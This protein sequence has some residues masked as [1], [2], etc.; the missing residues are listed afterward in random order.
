MRTRPVLNAATA[1]FLLVMGGCAQVETGTAGP[2]A[3][4]SD[5]GPGPGPRRFVFAEDQASVVV[6]SEVVMRGQHRPDSDLVFARRFGHPILGIYAGNAPDTDKLKKNLD[7][8]VEERIGGFKASTLRANEET[9]LSRQTILFLGDQ[10]WP[11]FVHFFYAG[12]SPEDAAAADRIIE[13][14]IFRPREA[15]DRDDFDHR[16]ETL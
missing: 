2:Q 3:L 6:T 4:A 16:T 7:A 12:L 14:M 9:G 15:P 1:A 11:V 10:G 5:P 8:V 13:S